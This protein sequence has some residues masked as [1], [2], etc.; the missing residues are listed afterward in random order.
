MGHLQPAISLSPGG[1]LA[2]AYQPLGWQEVDRLS[3]ARSG[4]S[5][6]REYGQFT[7]SRPVTNGQEATAS[8]LRAL[9]FSQFISYLS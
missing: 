8:D 6:D 5:L 4:H 2:D 3:S 7:D 9:G 1:L